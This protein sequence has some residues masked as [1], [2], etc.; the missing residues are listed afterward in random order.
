METK[1][2]KEKVVNPEKVEEKE[3]TVID[4]LLT[5]VEEL[6]RKDIE[7]QKQLKMLYDVAD[8]GRVFN[9][10][11]QRTEK[12][13][14]KIKLSVFAGGIIVGWRTLKDELVKHP[15]TGLTVGENQEYELIILD[16]ED[17]QKKVNVGSY[18]A[19]SNARYNERIEAEIV[20]KSEDY[21]GKI[22]YTVMLPD[23]RKISLGAQFIN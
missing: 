23:G 12:K 7:N 8:K 17:K 22:N 13:P 3:P 18:P 4:K 5:K 6:E 9:Y 20:S 10:E 11:N 2:K 21:D 15:T 1:I 14:F 19:F 16:S